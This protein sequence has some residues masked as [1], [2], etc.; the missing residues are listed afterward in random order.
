MKLHNKWFTFVELIVVV[1][2]LGILW[3]IG[4]V[5][6]TTYL[7]GSRDSNRITQLSDIKSWLSIYG[8]TKKLPNP[9]NSVNVLANANIVGTQWYAGASVLKQIGYQDGGIDPLNKTYFTYYLAKNGK[10]FQLLAFLE[11]QDVVSYNPISQ[12]YAAA[13]YSERFPTVTGSKL[14]V[15]LEDDTNTPIQEIGDVDIVTTGV[16]YNAYYSDEEVLSGT[17]GILRQ[18]ISNQ[19]CKR[20]LELSNHNGSG[21]YKI[22][23]TGA[24]EFQVYCDM[25]TDGGGWTRWAYVQK[26]DLLWNAY[27]TDMNPTQIA[28]GTGW[29]NFAQFSV[30]ANGEDLEYMVKVDGNIQKITYTGVKKEAWDYQDI[31]LMFD[32]QFYFKELGNSSYDLCTGNIR[33]SNDT[34][35]W[36]VAW[37]WNWI[38]GDPSWCNWYDA[39][40]IGASGFMINGTWEDPDIAYSI[41]WF[42]E[43]IDPTGWSNLQLYI[44]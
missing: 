43:Y 21:I 3:T 20:L 25:E 42:G 24:N 15:L 8:A 6:Y 38:L 17:G 18:T 27:T 35:N 9:E 1:V 23:P 32:D 40:V 12:T 41:Y 5:S 16:T 4:F 30:D 19:S 28:S 34:W 2:I 11:E 36:S 33:H 22:N 26:W 31:S 37:N 7:W 44:R 10:N 29:I 13:D 14:W 39:G